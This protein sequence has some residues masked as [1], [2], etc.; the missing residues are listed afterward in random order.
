MDGLVVSAC[1]ITAARPLDLDDRRAQIGELPGREGSSDGLLQADDGDPCSGAVEVIG[2]RPF[3]S[4]VPDV[5]CSLEADLRRQRRPGALRP[6]GHL[7]RGSAGPTHAHDPGRH[8]R[9]PHQPVVQDADHPVRGVNPRE[10]QREQ[11]TVNDEIRI[12]LDLR[13]IRPVEVDAVPVVGQ[14][15]EPE[16]QRGVARQL[17]APRPGRLGNARLGPATA[18]G[19]TPSGSDR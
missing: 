7:D 13:R 16:Q 1:E 12:A 2:N 9:R 15:A 18:R 17:Q 19:A 3:G 8:E 10:L 6:D 4:R 11:R 5:R 14:G